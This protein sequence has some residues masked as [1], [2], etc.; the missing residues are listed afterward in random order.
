MHL[1]SVRALARLAVAPQFALLLPAV[2]RSTL[3]LR[4]L[5]GKQSNRAARTLQQHEIFEIYAVPQYPMFSLHDFEKARRYVV[6]TIEIGG[7]GN[8]FRALFCNV[9]VVTS[10]P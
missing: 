1:A 2:A 3:I 8:L 10:S 9:H 5:H 7:F 6:F 4:T